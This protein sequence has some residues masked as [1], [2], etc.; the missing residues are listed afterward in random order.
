MRRS[1]VGMRPFLSLLFHALSARSLADFAELKS[2][3]FY[4]FGL[5]LRTLIPFQPRDRNG[6]Y[7]LLKVFRRR[8]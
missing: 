8:L 3:L 4:V 6:D 7:S 5:L 2:G 1:I